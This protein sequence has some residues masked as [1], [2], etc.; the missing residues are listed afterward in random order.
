[1]PITKETKAANGITVKFHKVLKLEVDLRTD[2]SIV[3]VASYPDEQAFLD[4]LPI[5]ATWV[6]NLP[7][8]ALS[9]EGTTLSQV[10]VA[11]T[12]SPT[13]PFY[14]GTLAVDKSESLEALKLRKN[15]EINRG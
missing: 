2:T 4:T 9:R 7:F 11:L 12:A 14:N 10:E 5:A 8:E 13:S 1:M 3:I 15:S 6:V